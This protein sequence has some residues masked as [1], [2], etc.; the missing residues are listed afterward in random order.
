MAPRR[1]IPRYRLLFL[2]LLSMILGSAAAA[3]LNVLPGPP[4]TAPPALSAPHGYQCNNL[5]SW[6][7]GHPGSPTYRRQDCNRAIG[8]FK[9]DVASNPGKAQWLSLGFPH[10]VP[11]YGLPVWTPK[12]YTFGES[13]IPSCRFRSCFSGRCDVDRETESRYMRAGD[14]KPRGRWRH[15]VE[16]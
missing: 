16:A 9:E 4:V 13:R 6:T 15:T 10:M 2:L 14:C 12:R 11:G 1:Q 7:G 3:S 5:P 8:M